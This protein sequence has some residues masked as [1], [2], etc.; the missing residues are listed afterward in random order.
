MSER[1]SE[2]AEMRTNEKVKERKDKEKRKR[3]CLCFHK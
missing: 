2:Q 3:E 1:A